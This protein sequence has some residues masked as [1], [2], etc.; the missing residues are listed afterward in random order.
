MTK[1]TINPASETNKATWL[2][3]GMRALF[4]A[5]AI[6]I[7][8]K[9]LEP[10]YGQPGS[11][12]IDKVQ[13]FLAYFILSG[14]ALLSRM[15]LRRVSLLLAILVFSAAIEILQGAMNMGRTASFA[16]FL[17]NLSGVLVAWGVWRVGQL[18]WH[19]N[20]KKNR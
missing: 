18:L 4:A 1:T 2:N 11:H 10:F 14:L 6:F 3:W 17:A 20:V 13:H 5:L 9:S 7:L 12:Y 16:D 8:W 15:P 19:K